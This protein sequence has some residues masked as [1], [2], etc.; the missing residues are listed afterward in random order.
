MQRK[1][2]GG[3][4]LAAVLSVG[5]GGSVSAAPVDSRSAERA[6]I[7][8]LDAELAGDSGGAQAAVE[9][10]RKRA[11][12]PK[13]AVARQLLEAWLEA[14]DERRPAWKPSASRADV[15]R[16]WDSLDGFSW[17]IHSRAWHHL[18]ERRPEL[19]SA[20]PTVT[21]RIDRSRGVSEGELQAA[22]VE[23]LRLRQVPVGEGPLELGVDFDATDQSGSERR[24]QV[25]ARLDFV[26][27]TTDLPPR[28][29]LRFARTRKAV[30]AGA[31]AARRFALRRLALDAG[32]S[33]SGA[34]R[35]WAISERW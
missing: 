1:R 16:A 22:L 26:L 11:V 14:A 27:T 25:R 6:L 4:T 29:V 2:M 10:L 20:L 18:V 21:V 30:R 28:S 8:A 31:E 12:S 15:L 32:R 7:L 3:R 24:T 13:E 35:R 17:D 5:L 23:G 19:K 9:A 33:V 34:A